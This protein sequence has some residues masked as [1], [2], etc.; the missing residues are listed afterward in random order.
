MSHRNMEVFNK[1]KSQAYRLTSTKLIYEYQSMR[2]VILYVINFTSIDKTLYHDLNFF[3]TCNQVLIYFHIKYF[4]KFLL[5]FLS[6]LQH[7]LFYFILFCYNWH[8]FTLIR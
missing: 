4:E 8:Y 3:G 5:D 6:Y 1:F 2:I 7:P